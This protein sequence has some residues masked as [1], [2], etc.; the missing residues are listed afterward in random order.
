MNDLTFGYAL[1]GSFCTFSKS[2]K[3]MR[4]LAEQGYQLLPVMSYNAAKD[5][6]TIRQSIRF[7]TG[8]AGD[9]WPGRDPDHC[10]GGTDRS[11]K[12]G[13]PDDCSPVYREYAGEARKRH[14]GYAGHNG[15]Q[16]EFAH[17]PSGAIGARYK[18]R[19][20]G[21]RTE[22]RKASQHEETSILF[23]LHRTIRRKKPYSLVADFEK[24][25]PAALA[26]LEGRQLQ[27]ILG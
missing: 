14:Y 24:L 10:R 1:C 11:Q 20:G 9:F 22:H 23:P 12:N 7:F 5:G 8:A 21:F 17:W 13:G 6:H 4:A 15:G 26:A 3:Q 19:V 16:I 27:P 2:L 25:L 18:R